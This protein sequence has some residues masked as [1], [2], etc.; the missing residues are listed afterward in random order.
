MFVTHWYV[1]HVHLCYTF[2]C[3]ARMCNSCVLHNDMCHTTLTCIIT[4]T[5]H[6]YASQVARVE[7]IDMAG[8]QMD[9]SWDQVGRD[10]FMC[11]TTHSYFWHDSCETYLFI[12]V[13]WL[14]YMCAMHVVSHWYAWCNP[15]N[16]TDP[17]LVLRHVWHDSFMCVAWLIHMCDMTHSY[18]WQDSF[19]C[20]TRL[21]HMCDMT[22]SYV[23]QRPT[24]EACTRSG[25]LF[26]I[27]YEP[28]WVK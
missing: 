19:I 24:Q 26:T 4:H 17:R 11:M 1:L 2:I 7:P 25:V 21:I 28:C 6:V 5:C 9:F 8:G 10:S 27:V 18:V 3:V 15:F 22:H 23:W 14:N 12:C 16:V 20:V 13:T